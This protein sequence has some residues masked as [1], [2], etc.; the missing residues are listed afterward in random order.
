MRIIAGEF[1]RRA[2]RPPPDAKTTRPI[3]DR[4]K[5]ALFN[6]LRG[7][8]EGQV[9]IDVFA[10]TGSIGL[11]AL[12]RG[13]ERVVFVERDRSILPV[14]RWNIETL[15]VE[16]RCSVVSADAL[17]PSAVAQCPRP[18]H[19]VFFDPPYALMGEAGSRGLALDAL[20]RYVGLLDPEGFASLRTPWPLRDEPGGE[21]RS[22]PLDPAEHL[23]VEG[24]DGPETHVYSSMAV[25]LYAPAR[26][27]AASG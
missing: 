19:L 26:A 4:V 12:S 11:E 9:V 14:L 10:G 6:L 20:A 22:A 17:G 25:H 15:G 16:D 13:A 24:A 8:V 3:T 2:L 5:E 23:P 21:G 18:A 7:H 1:R 27:A